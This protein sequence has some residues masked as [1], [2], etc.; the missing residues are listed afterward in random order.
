MVKRTL[1]AEE[2][3]VFVLLCRGYSNKAISDQLGLS[4]RAVESCIFRAYG[5]LEPVPSAFVRRAYFAY[6]GGWRD[7]LADLDRKKLADVPAMRAIQV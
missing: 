2:A 5:K 4:L 1:T 3:E 6:R 7:A